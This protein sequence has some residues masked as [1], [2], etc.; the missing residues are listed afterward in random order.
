MEDMVNKSNDLFDEECL[1]CGIIFSFKDYTTI[2]AEGNI[3]NS[4]S[5]AEK[6]GYDTEHS[7]N[8]FDEK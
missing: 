3:Y 8:F 2:T 4:V 1:H 5:V 7:R 6:N